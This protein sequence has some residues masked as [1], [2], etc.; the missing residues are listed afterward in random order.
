M[1][2]GSD[3]KWVSLIEGV[4]TIVRRGEDGGRSAEFIT[5]PQWARYERDR[6]AMKHGMA[7]GGDPIAVKLAKLLETEE[8]KLLDSAEKAFDSAISL[9]RELLPQGIIR[10]EGLHEDTH[11]R[12]PITESEWATRY[13]NF[14]ENELQH[15]QGHT[16]EEYAWIRAVA[17]SA[18]D[19]R[20]YAEELA[21]RRA[22]ELAKLVPTRPDLA[23]LIRAGRAQKGR[24]LT[25]EE[26][27]K[28]A[29]DDSEFST[30]EKLRETLK[31]VQGKAKRGRPSRSK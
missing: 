19:V 18:D 15:P 11:L 14:W 22:K 8:G 10:G 1:T 12:G 13:I 7:Y 25:Y 4:R 24:D 17:I 9:L 5:C 31:Q 16:R 6:I 3:S 23:A 20:P 26:A 30:R 2:A 29:N 28:I 21:K 27:Q